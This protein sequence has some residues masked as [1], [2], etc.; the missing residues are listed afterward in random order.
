M[1]TL[2]GKKK[3]GHYAHPSRKKKKMEGGIMHT[4]AGKKEQMREM[5]LGLSARARAHTHTHIHTRT[6]T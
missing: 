5:N 2:A 3:E 6:H 1:H 4:L